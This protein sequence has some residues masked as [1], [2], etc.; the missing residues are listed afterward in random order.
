MDVEAKSSSGGGDSEDDD[1]SD[2]AARV[3]DVPKTADGEDEHIQSPS[4][5]HPE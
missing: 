2:D 4:P 1:V 5:K 3:R